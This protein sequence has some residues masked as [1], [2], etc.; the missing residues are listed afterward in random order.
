MSLRAA[1]RVTLLL[2][3]VLACAS[4]GL[5][6]ASAGTP[7]AAPPASAGA[8]QA[9]GARAEAAEATA[10]VERVV[11]GIGAMRGCITDTSGIAHLFVS[12]TPRDG[13]R[14]ERICVDPPVRANT[15]QCA[16]D[17]RALRP[18][19]YT[20]TLTAVDAAGNRGSFDQAYRVEPAPAEPVNPDDRTTTVPEPAPDPD[21]ETPAPAEPAPAEPGPV[22]PSPAQPEPD[23]VAPETM[24]EQLVSERLVECA[25][26]ELAPGVLADRALS[27]AVL[28]CM[29]PALEA[30]GATGLGLDEIPVPPAIRVQLPDAATQARADELLPERIGGVELQLVLPDVQDP[31]PAAE[32]ADGTTPPE[33]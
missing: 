21:P 7:L 3:T 32:P 22:Q 24:L 4:T 20:V 2:G 13:G 15:W 12:W 26:L 6:S 27:V 28:A 25:Q 10:A 17:T 18:G 31:A 19:S 8:V 14:T 29:R 16:W 33:A 9:C 11:R 1:H 30:L 5:P 23:P